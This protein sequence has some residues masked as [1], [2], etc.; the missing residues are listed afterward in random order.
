MHC[1]KCGAGW[2]AGNI[3]PLISACPICDTNYTDNVEYRG[4]DSI[5]EFL[6]CVL[7]ENGDA[8]CQDKVRVLGLLNDFFPREKA[9][10]KDIEILLNNG[11]GD[12]VYK[13]RENPELPIDLTTIVDQK[14]I[15]CSLSVIEN[16]IEY[17]TGR[18]IEEA[19]AVNTADYYLNQ[20]RLLQANEYKICSLKKA[21]AIAPQNDALKAQ[22]ELLFSVGN[23]VEAIKTLD[24]AAER[25]DE[26]SL[27]RLSE[28]YECGDKLPKDYGKAL[29][30]LNILKDLG[31][32]EGLYHLGRFYYLGYGVDKNI[33]YAVDFLSQAAEKKHEKALYILYKILYKSN[34]EAAIGYLKKAAELRYDLAMYDYAVHQL[35]GDDVQKNVEEAVK[36]LE[37]CAK[38]KHKGAI[39]KLAY[40]YSTGNGISADKEKA[41]KYR[42]LSGD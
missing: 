9:L 12:L 23:N 5:S 35:Y 16:C 17:L 29:A 27:L 8:V 21:N 15:S 26:E 30:Y 1:L 41:Q 11:L 42:D 3:K 2:T 6:L 31:N 32:R 39:S 14:E 40:L 22:A 19:S 34:K 20:Y 38:Y 28:I 4:Y 7:A 24:I 25:K 37:A 10:R 33:N 36:L 18:R 13:L